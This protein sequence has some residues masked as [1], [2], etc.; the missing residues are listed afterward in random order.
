MLRLPENANSADAQELIGVAYQKNKQ[1]GEARAEYEDYLRRYPSGEGAESV[2]QRLAAIVTAETPREDKLRSAKQGDGRGERGPSPTTWSMSGSAS[3]FYVRDD[4]FRVLRDPSLPINPNADKDDH[5][6]HRNA[7]LSS[8]DLFA[9]WG[10]DSYKSKFRFSGSEEHRFGQDDT[11]IFSVSALFYEM[12]VKDWGTMARIGRQTRNTGGVLGRFDGGLVSWQANPWLRWNVVGGSPVASRKDAPFKDEKLIYGTS[13]DFGP[14]WGGFDASLFAVEQ[15]AGDLIDRQA[16]GTE[17]RYLDQ[18]RSA[19][20]TVDYDTHFSEFNAAIF[21]GSWT[22][23]DKSTLH[24]GADYRKAPY[25]TSWNALQ[26]QQ[27]L[28]LFELLKL[29]TQ[30]EITQMALDRTATYTSANVGYSRPLTDKWQL[31]LDTTAA[32]IDGT[33]ASFGID[34]MPSTGN[35]LYY[36]AQLIGSSLFRDGDMFI[37]GVRFADRQDS[38]TYVLDLSTRFPLMQDWRINP[39][40]LLS[41]REGKTTE[42]TEVSVLPSILLNYY[43]TKDLSLELEVGAKWTR[44]DEASVRDTETEF[45]LTAGFRY[46]FYADGRR[47]PAGVTS[48]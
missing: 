29:R 36:S 35:E 46:D 15:R 28:T 16:V 1:P 39:R 8:I 17:L 27:V 10:D 20:L 48:C 47:C 40:V 45:F 7:L 24:G 33:I 21:S 42:F 31:N 4:S 44:R 13:V 2:R 9:A 5:R 37:T 32:H 14:F 43:W 23:P 30:S 19:F 41:H 6:V 25:L 38:N 22:L 3:Q 12:A 18:T 26:G 11:D 34:A